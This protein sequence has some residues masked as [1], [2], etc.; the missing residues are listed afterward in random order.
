MEGGKK[1]REKR[2][3]AERESAREARDGKKA[4]GSR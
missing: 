3:D 4:V 2:T 1:V